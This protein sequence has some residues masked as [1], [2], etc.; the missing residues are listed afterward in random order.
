MEEIMNNETIEN[1]EEETALTV[2]ETEDESVPDTNENSGV[3]ALAIGAGLCGLA[4]IG[5][6][7]VGRATW[8]HVLKPIGHKIKGA[9]TKEKEPVVVTDAAIE[10]MWLIS[11]TRICLNEFRATA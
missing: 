1:T 6:V 9:F 3:G 8:K 11:I 7:T 4:V 10:V 5:A 2:P